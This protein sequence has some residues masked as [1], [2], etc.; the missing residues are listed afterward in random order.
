MGDFKK[1]EEESGPEEKHKDSME[2]IRSVGAIGGAQSVW[3][4]LNP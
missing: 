1:K 3:L 4:T 2:V